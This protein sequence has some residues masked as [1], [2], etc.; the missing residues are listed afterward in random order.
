[1]HDKPNTAQ[2]VITAKEEAGLI[3][4]HLESFG[5]KVVFAGNEKQAL[6]ELNEDMHND[7][8]LCFVCAKLPHDG[9]RT[10]LTNIRRNPRLMFMPVIAL[11]RSCESRDIFTAVQTGAN[12]AITPSISIDDFRDRVHQAI[13]VGSRTVLVVDDEAMIL[14]ILKQSLQRE[15]LR[16]ITATSVDQ[17]VQ[18]LESTRVHAVVSDILMPGRNG[19]EL[20]VEVKERFPHIPMIMITG[21]SGRFSPKDCIAAGADAYFTKPF[22]NVEIVRTLRAVL[23]RSESRVNGSPA[24]PAFRSG[25]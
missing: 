2:I 7:I 17:A 12:S 22:K 10:L 14:D 13:A 8:E 16:V 15:R 6:K 9:F 23:A 21:Y 24:S 1:M 11:C 3:P 4:S 20:L 5:Y 18:Y 25:T 19:F